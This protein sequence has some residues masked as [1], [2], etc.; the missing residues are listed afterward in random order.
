MNT[1]IKT[2]RWGKL[3][4]F[5][6]MVVVLVFFCCL[7]PVHA[8]QTVNR[9]NT[10]SN[11]IT[12]TTENNVNYTYQINQTITGAGEPHDTFSFSVSGPGGYLSTVGSTTRSTDGDY[13]VGAL[14]SPGVYWT[15]SQRQYVLNMFLKVKA[16]AGYT[17]RSATVSNSQSC[18]FW[19]NNDDGRVTSATGDFLLNMSTN[20]NGMSNLSGIGYQ[21]DSYRV[22]YEPNTYQVSYNANGGSGYMSNSNH[23]YGIGK[24]LTS[25]NYNKNYTTTLNPNGGS[26]GTASLSSSAAFANWSNTSGGS[27]VYYDGALVS[28][29]TTTNNGTKTLYARWGNATLGTLPTPTRTGY[30][31]SGWYTS[32]SGGSQVTTGATVNS[33]STL[34]AHWTGNPYHV[35]YNPNAG[36]GTIT[37]VMSN[38]NHVYGTAKN[39]TNRNFSKSYVATF[40][41]NGGTVGTASAK[42]DC[43]FDGWAKTAS[44]WTWTYANQ[45]SVINLTPTK[46]AIYD[47][48]ADWGNATYGTLPTPTRTGYTFSGWYT[49]SGG[50][51]QVNSGTALTGDTTVYAH[52]DLNSYYISYNKNSGV[53]SMGN[54]THWYNIGDN[55]SDND[56]TKDYTVLFN[57]NGGSVGTSS[58]L[59]NCAMIGWATTPAGMVAY[60]DEAWVMN[61]SL[62]NNVTILLYAK[63]A[64]A[65]LGGS[66]TPTRT[67]YLFNGWF[68]ASSGGSQVSDGATITANTQLYA[69]WTAITYQVSYDKT[70]GNSAG[71]MANSGHVY[72]VAKNL[73]NETYTK[74][75]T[76]SFD[77]TG[78]S[79][80][81]ASLQSN[82][83]F[84]K[85]A[86]TP[87]GSGVYSN[88]QSVINLTTVNNAIVPLYATW[89]KAVLSG[90]PL[91]SRTGYIFQ[92]W[93]TDASGGSQI[94]NGAIITDHTT[95]YAHWIPIVY[96]VSYDK[97]TG[98]G[99]MANSNHI[100][101]V[102]RP[103]TNNSFTKNY[104]VSFNPNATGGAVSPVSTENNCPFAGWATSPAGGVV[105]SNAQAVINLTA[106]NNAIVPLYAKW[107]NATLGATPTPSLTGY[108]FLGWFTAAVGGTEV[109]TGSTI[110][111]HTTVY[112]HWEPIK[113]W[114]QFDPNSVNGIGLD[115]PGIVSGSMAN[116]QL[117]YDQIQNLPINKYTKTTVSNQ[118][119]EA[120]PDITKGGTFMG[121]SLSPTTLTPTFLDQQQ[122]INL[123]T[124]HDATLVF[125]AIWDDSPW[126]IITDYPNRYFTVDE[127]TNGYITPTELLRTV[128]AYDRETNPL[129]KGAT[130]GITVANYGSMFT[131]LTRATLPDEAATDG[132]LVQYNLE[133]A[134]G[135]KS[136][137]KIKVYI[138]DVVPE[139]VT[140]VSYIRGIAGKTYRK[141]TDITTHAKG[142]FKAAYE[143]G[144]NAASVWLTNSAYTAM[145]DDTIKNEPVVEG[146]AV[147]EPTFQ[148][149]YY[150]TAEDLDKI[151]DDVIGDTTDVTSGGFGVSGL[152]ERMQNGDYAPR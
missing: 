99:A 87:A 16:V 43:A 116:V 71:N 149:S 10:G 49:T 132:Y 97:T 58:V 144:L 74:N 7:S 139:P 40:N 129:I 64:N 138:T 96:Q 61:L 9:L 120:G 15:E 101:D 55:L 147:S 65:T 117:T 33:N 26:V 79:V 59:A 110:T 5:C 78:G 41:A 106:V 17:P 104:T 125:Y 92:G 136:V 50:G 68:T 3:L 94:S 73:T 4:S 60:A 109:A 53:G 76:V 100:Y 123:T 105:Y 133:D 13:Y 75:W 23:V 135:H 14:R 91:P 29:L 6:F 51:S 28:N 108:N 115:G 86:T 30:T 88:S 102:S 151:H 143:G 1:K 31:F 141:P 98:I 56:F 93:F 145:L 2:K 32:A 137:L 67:G 42:R 84:L 8:S 113:Y 19:D 38:S 148:K 90:S 12:V 118:E 52:W 39:L 63:W 34:Y 119:T 131:S 152:A 24:Y 103:L 44:A 127:A 22:W 36:T 37:G 80:A 81:P 112:A 47:I 62:L 27:L 134:M 83:A 20:A 111:E 21:N 142:G 57:P 146:V 25:N 45:E 11:I 82:C 114:V 48:Y 107:N 150:F 85:W 130:P 46:D 89:D 35:K 66:P 72:D 122:V 69:H 128:I 95:L 124:T 18:F 140:L 126:F 54:S 121:W 70:T 77:P